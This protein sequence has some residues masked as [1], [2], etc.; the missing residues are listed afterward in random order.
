M[1]QKG[2]RFL[3]RVLPVVQ[4]TEV[5]FPNDDAV[6]HNVF[7]LSKP[8]PFDLGVY[9][10]GATRSVTFPETGL[11][12][13]FCNIHPQMTASILILANPWFAVTDPGGLFVITDVPD[14]TWSFRAWHELG[15]GETVP[16]TVA[17]G[18]ALRIDPAIRETSRVLQP[19][20]NKFGQPYRGK[21][22]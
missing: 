15:G 20:K 1:S 9:S 6:F 18:V 3:P 22:R 2:Q 11:V 5:R 13:V 14:G 21:Y 12:R 17:G 7:S 4:D 16:V 10:Q 19:H 8:K